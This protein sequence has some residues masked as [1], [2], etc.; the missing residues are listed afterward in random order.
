[1]GWSLAIYD[2]EQDPD[3]TAAA[4]ILDLVRAVAAVLPG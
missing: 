1:M 2:P 4:D 3:R